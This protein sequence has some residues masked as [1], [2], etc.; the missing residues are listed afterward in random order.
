MTYSPTAVVINT[1]K[2]DDVLFYSC[3]DK[4]PQEWWRII[5]QL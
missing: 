1:H 3:S 5:L 4:H 2:N